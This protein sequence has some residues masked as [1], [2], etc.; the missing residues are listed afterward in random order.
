ME[1]LEEIAFGTDQKSVKMA[2]INRQYFDDLA[3]WASKI[4]TIYSLPQ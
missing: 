2:Q 1:H 3:T 4:A